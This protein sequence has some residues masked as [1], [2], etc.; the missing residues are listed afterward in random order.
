MLAERSA[1][2]MRR[3]RIRQI[4]APLVLGILFLTSLFVG[5]GTSTVLLAIAVAVSVIV[6]HLIWPSP[7]IVIAAV[8]V[9]VATLMPISAMYIVANSGQESASLAEILSL[10][11]WWKNVIPLVVAIITACVLRR[12][13]VGPGS[14]SPTS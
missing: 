13:P 5:A 1:T 7:V 4:G 6:S 9:V 3:E 11:V 14:K 12:L 2:A 10:F 8:M